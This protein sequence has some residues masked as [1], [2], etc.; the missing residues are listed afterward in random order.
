MEL[1]WGLLRLAAA[2]VVVGAQLPV[3]ALRL[4]NQYR[5]RCG[6]ILLYK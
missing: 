5:F 4:E 3:S 1:V 6:G 2:A